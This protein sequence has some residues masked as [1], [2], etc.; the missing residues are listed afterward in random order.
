M[1]IGIAGNSNF[2]D[3]RLRQGPTADKGECVRERTTRLAYI[4][5]DYKKSIDGGFES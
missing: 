2:L 4:P 5:C 3:S 1:A